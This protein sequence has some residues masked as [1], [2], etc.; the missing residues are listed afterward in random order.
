[1]KGSLL[2]FTI[3]LYSGYC[4]HYHWFKSTNGEELVVYVDVPYPRLGSITGSPPYHASNLRRW[5]AKR[6]DLILL[7]FDPDKLLGPD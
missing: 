3:P 7:L 1:M 2:T 6:S 4:M 5:W